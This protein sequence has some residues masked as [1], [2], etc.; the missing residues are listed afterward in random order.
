MNYYYDS[1]TEPNW[2]VFRGFLIDDLFFISSDSVTEPNW[3]VGELGSW[4]VGE[5]GR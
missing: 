3:G 1:V 2:G 5:L 4:G